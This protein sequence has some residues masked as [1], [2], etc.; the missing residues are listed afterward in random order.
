MPPAGQRAAFK[1]NQHRLDGV[2]GILCV[3]EIA[4]ALGLIECAIFLAAIIERPLRRR[5][6]NGSNEIVGACGDALPILFGFFCLGFATAGRCFKSGREVGKLLHA[7]T[8]AGEVGVSLDAAGHVIADGARLIPVGAVGADDVIDKPALFFPAF[9][10][11]FAAI[12]GWLLCHD[13]SSVH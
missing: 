4:I 12:D 13:V 11:R 1:W 7:L 5:V 3:S 9:D 10:V 8:N 2:V 6:L